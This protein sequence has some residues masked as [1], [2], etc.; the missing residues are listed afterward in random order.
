VSDRF[1]IRNSLKQ[2]DALTPMLFNFALVYT[3]R[4]VEVKRNGLKL[5]DTH[6]VM[7]YADDVN[8]LGGS[9]LTL[10]EKCRSI[11]SCY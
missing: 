11:N 8:I 5:N 7:A 9:I 10:K 6:Q 2:G 1:H 4:R 3:I